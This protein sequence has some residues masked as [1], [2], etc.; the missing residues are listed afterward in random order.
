M[1][2]LTAG[3]PL[4]DAVVT[5]KQPLAA[6]SKLTIGSGAGSSAV[7]TLGPGWSELPEQSN[8]YESYLLRRGAVELSIIDVDLVNRSQVRHL[9]QGLGQILSVSNPGIRIGRAAHIYT[10]DGMRAITGIIVGPRKVGTA[11]IFPG[12]SRQFAVEVLVLAPRGTNP[13]L[14]AAALRIVRS[15]R[16]TAAHR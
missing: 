9:W 5:N 6:G 8:P 16:F 4:V 11:T 13:A 12:P 7:V 3:W 2:L 1:A 14:R 15:L 10:I